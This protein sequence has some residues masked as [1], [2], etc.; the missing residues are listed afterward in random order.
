[1]STMEQVPVLGKYH[2]YGSYSDTDAIWYKQ[3]PSHWK[4]ER[5]KYHFVEKKKRSASDLSAGAISFGEVVYKDEEKLSQETKD[6]YQEV[7]SGEFLVNPLNLNFDLKS[8]RTALS[9]I[10]AVVST[11]YI[12]L[13]GREKIYPRFARWLLH[14]FDVSHMKTLGSGVRQTINYADIGNSL[15]CLP[16]ADEQRTIAAFLDYETARIDKLIAQQQRLIELLKEKRQAVISHAVTKGLNPDAPMKDSG[17]EWLGE[18]PELWGVGRIGYYCR[19]ENGTTPSKLNQEYWSDGSVPWLSSGAV[20]QY[21]ITE[22]SEM[23]SVTALSECSLRLLPKNTLVVGMIGQGKTR[24]MSAIT[25]ISASINQNLAAIIPNAKISSD[26]L[27]FVLQAAYVALRETGRGGNQAALNCEL[28]SDLRFAKPDLDT[29]LKIVRYLK[30]KCSQFDK[31][32]ERTNTSLELL[33]ERRTAL[34]S[35][36]VTG[37]I[38]LRYWAEPI[39]EVAA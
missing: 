5:F 35:A 21:E 27:H 11:G 39:K 4:C 28:I 1:M 34:I 24:G 9:S 13:Q 3:K 23:I 12:V 17:V 25:R 32:T 29:Q 22:A 20:N 6:S 31:V 33:Q 16:P 38:D 15:F 2:S 18:V 7:L 30:N 14:Q 10:D 36:A 37:K 8:L 19:I 26:F